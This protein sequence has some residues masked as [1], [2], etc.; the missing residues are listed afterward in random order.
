M[1]GRGGFRKLRWKDPTRGKD[2]RGGP[3]I[4]CYYFVGDRQVWLMTLH[5]KNQASDLT[6]KEEQ[7]LNSAIGSELQARQEIKARKTTAMP[8]VKEMRKGKIFEQR[9]EVVSATKSDRER[10]ITTAQL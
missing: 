6:P 9:M 3:R 1:P 8:R 7:M 2:Q 5:D 10:K 4:I